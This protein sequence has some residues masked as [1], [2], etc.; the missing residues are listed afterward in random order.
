MDYLRNVLEGGRGEGGSGYL[1]LVLFLK[2][3]PYMWILGRDGM[4]RVVNFL[5]VEIFDRG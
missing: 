5:V 2:Y 3:I 4:G 1:H